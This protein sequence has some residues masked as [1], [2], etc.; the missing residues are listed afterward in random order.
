[1]ENRY[2]DNSPVV[3]LLSNSDFVAEAQSVVVED[4][5][6]SNLYDDRFIDLASEI[7][8]ILPVK[9]H[10]RHE[11]NKCHEIY[12]LIQHPHSDRL[13]GDR[14]AIGILYVVAQKDYLQCVPNES[15]ELYTGY[16][17][18]Q[19]EE[20]VQ[21]LENLRLIESTVITEGYKER[22]DIVNNTSDIMSKIQSIKDM[23]KNN[24]SIDAKDI[25][26]ILGNIGEEEKEDMICMTEDDFVN[27]MVDAIKAGEVIHVDTESEIS[28]I[29][30]GTKGYRMC[31]D[32][33]FMKNLDKLS[34]L[35][36]DSMDKINQY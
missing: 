4:T 25:S 27:H 33:E 29:E 3:E 21:E 1:M 20:K 8:F 17:S 32:T 12:K 16:D 34:F 2:I 31:D 26:S 22:K 24:E 15:L 28:N 35:L 14:I 30:K 7:G 23:L 18:N 13:L 19:I 11:V 10:D 5:V 6:R 36:V 9:G